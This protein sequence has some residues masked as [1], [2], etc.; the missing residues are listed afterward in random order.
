MARRPIGVA[1]GTRDIVLVCLAVMLAACAPPA[2]APAPGANQQ[3]GAEPS[4]SRRG[5]TITVPVTSAVP[6]LG[7][8]GIA[9]TSTGGWGAASEI[10]ANGLITSDVHTRKPIGRLA[11]RVPS[12]DDGTIS[13]LPDGR[14]RVAY[15]LRKG[16]TW[17]DGVPF[18]AQDLVFS[19][20]F[21]TDPG[22]PSLPSDVT[23][24]MESVEA[25]DDATF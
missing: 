6:A 24:Q 13:V 4:Q 18:T 14:M 7:I 9:S 11:E 23:R 20:Q 12:L 2:T 22:I 10:Y 17:Q 15:S 25:P 21:N 19:Y 8:V 3:R 1:I 16:V 5:G